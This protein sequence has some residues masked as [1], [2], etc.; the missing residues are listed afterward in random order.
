MQDPESLEGVGPAYGSLRTA[1]G[2]HQ[3][4]LS[5]GHGG[6]LSEGGE[7]GDTASC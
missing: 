7:E 2:N 6:W 4:S 3:L 1:L 5:P